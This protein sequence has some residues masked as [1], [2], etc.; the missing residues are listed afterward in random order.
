MHFGVLVEV[1]RDEVG[2]IDS[3]DFDLLIPI[4]IA[5]MTVPKGEVL[6]TDRNGLRVGFEV[7]G[8]RAV[9]IEYQ[10]VPARVSGAAC[11]GS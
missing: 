7:L 4:R 11:S 8:D 9:D 2:Y 1:G 3:E 10:P 6:P 5:D